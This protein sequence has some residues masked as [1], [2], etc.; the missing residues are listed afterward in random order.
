MH[1]PCLRRS[2]LGLASLL[3]YPALVLGP[4]FLCPPLHAE[5]WSQFRGDDG[6]GMSQE[7]DFP[8]QWSAG[9]IKWKV[10]LPGIG[11]SSPVIWENKVFLTSAGD[12]GTVRYVLC[13]D[14]GTGKTL[15]TRQMEFNSNRKHAKSSWASSTPAVDGERVYVV[16]ADTEKQ[17]LAAYDFTGKIVWQKDLGSYQSQHGQGVSPI[18]FENL[19]IL[20]NDQDGPSSMIACD[21]RTG[22][23]VWSVT[24]NSGPQST[25]YATPFLYRPKEGPPQLICASALSG[26]S[27]L[28]PRTGR[29][30][31]TTK[32]LP[33]RTVA[34]PVLAA[35]LLFQ[36]CGAQGQGKLMIAVDP[37]GKGDVSKT[38]IRYSRTQIL[39]YVPTPVAFRDYL[40]LWS[41]HGIVCCMDPHTGKDVWTK[42]VGGDFSAS[43]ICASGML[44]NSDENGNVIVLAASGEF[45]LLGKIPLGD[46]CHS[47]AAVANGRLYFHT[48]HH[49]VCVAAKPET[50]SGADGSRRQSS[51]KDRLSTRQGSTASAKINSAVRNP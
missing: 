12:K 6:T 8:S 44:F 48:F 17:I 36:C 4:A 30:I 21:K 38:H 13:L 29:T 40:F 25:S 10:D 14:A 26:V 42:R 37:D 28:D 3:L 34:S 7:C 23:T 24:R 41:D 16:L 49:L 5:N 20:A 50:A 35:G 11:H 22:R 19:V 1:Q 18:L 51:E 31:W 15:W 33:Q 47:T 43:P 39:P 46:Q 2:P 45:K 9:Q 32:S 27:A